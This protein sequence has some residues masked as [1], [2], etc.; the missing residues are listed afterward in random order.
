MPR[1]SGK[2]ISSPAAYA[3]LFTAFR[4]PSRISFDF[5]EGESN[6]FGVPQLAH[7]VPDYTSAH[8]LRLERAG[9][10]ILGKT[11]TPEFGHKATT[12]NRLFGPTSTPFAVG[13]NAGGSSGGS[14]AAV[15]DG[16]CALAQ[17]SDGGGSVRIPA[18]L[19]GVVG[20][21][22]TYGRL[23]AVVRPDAFFTLSPF[24]S[25]GPLARTVED[26]ALM[27]DAMVGVDPLDPTSVGHDGLRFRDAV[28]QP[29]K[30]LRVAYLPTLGGFPV[31]PVVRSITDDAVAELSRAGLS[32]EQPEFHLPAPHQEVT[33]LWVRLAGSSLVGVIETFTQG[34]IDLRGDGW[35]ELPP[36]LRKAAERG[37]R[38]TA[39]ET[40]MDLMLRTAIFDALADVF[41]TYDVIISPTV[42]VPP[43][44]NFTDG[45]TVGPDSINGEDV[46]PTLGWCLTHPF[47]FSG[48]P[49][50]SVPG[51]FTDDGLPVGL[52]IA[53]RRFADDVVLAVAAMFERIR[54]WYSRYLELRA[55][56]H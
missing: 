13:K 9:A 11:N 46:D 44:D 51:G 45:W 31:D 50:I 17:G 33:D 7:Y 47:N 6:S 54:P 38:Q 32:V 42:A 25:N 22:P 23:A 27:L 37:Y 49:A 3:G 1:G 48:H 12:D 24:M 43:F 28:L 14:A 39:V 52:Q 55:R 36:H 4:S 19:C 56:I 53:G 5:I 18:A 15:A 10:I 34:G 35:E 21:K 8:V 40:R 20:M 16:L 29:T 41:S 26:C 30:H 2:R